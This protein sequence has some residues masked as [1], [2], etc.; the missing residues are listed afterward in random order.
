VYF[1]QLSLR[2]IQFLLTIVRHL[3][4]AK[5]DIVKIL[6]VL[7]NMFQSP[8]NFPHLSSFILQ[9]MSLF[10]C[11]SS[12]I[13]LLLRCS[14]SLLHV[15]RCFTTSLLIYNFWVDY[16][17]NKSITLSAIAFLDEL[18][19]VLLDPKYQHVAGPLL[20][21]IQ[22]IEAFAGQ[23]G[24]STFAD[25]LRNRMIAA[26]VIHT[27]VGS[28]HDGRQVL[29]ETH[30]R[31]LMRIADQYMATPAMR[32]KWLRQIVI[33]NKKENDFISAFVAQLH[34]IALVATVFDHMKNEA[35]PRLD[36]IPQYHLCIVQP[37]HWAYPPNE[38]PKR[39]TFLDFSFMPDVLV[40]TE[41]DFTKMQANEIKLLDRFTQ[42]MLFEEID[43]G[44]EI[45]R[46]AKIFYSLRPLLS[47]KLRLYYVLR[48]YAEIAKVCQDLDDVFRNLKTSG[49]THESPFLFFF[50][51]ERYRG[52]VVRQVYTWPRDTESEF[53]ERFC[54]LRWFRV[55]IKMCTVHDGCSQNGVCVVVME[56]VADVPVDGEHPHCWS[57]F[58]SRVSMA[59]WVDERRQSADYPVLRVVTKSPLPH[60]RI[61][62]EVAKVGVVKVPLVDLVKQTA[63]KSAAMLDQVSAGFEVWFETEP[64]NPT[65]AANLF[66]K[67]MAKFGSV[68]EETLGPKESLGGRLHRLKKID[69][70][71]ATVIAREFMPHLARIMM[72]FR[73]AVEE[74]GVVAGH[75]EALREWTVKIEKFADDFGMQ[76]LTDEVLMSRPN[77]MN[78]KFPYEH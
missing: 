31:E 6:R 45:G 33:S 74:V 52:E 54:S 2:T 57:E 68:L 22:K 20:L 34:V 11:D 71:E 48:N 12:L 49:L 65:N 16:Q 60:Y 10:E 36:E 70:T 32:L 59:E 26:E 19:N 75:D 78:R 39:Q 73:R 38:Y 18:T 40:E 25:A 29:Q 61:A 14:G 44:I 53:R 50:V 51:E 62:N 56:P 8:D 4:E 7:L 41:I 67:E 27:A 42:Q 3:G 23:M 13:H 77:P 66:G 15:T 21:T 28:Q 30:C 69:R 47:L 72:V 63:A 17:R 46:T 55:P 5:K 58:A 64:K 37:I 43:R 9:Y 1:D 76:R 35:K 24:D